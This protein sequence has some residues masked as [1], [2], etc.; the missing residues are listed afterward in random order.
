M[1]EYEVQWSR[2]CLTDSA[3]WPIVSQYCRSHWM[4]MCFLT[5]LVCCR[6]LLIPF[7]VCALPVAVCKAALAV[8]MCWFEGR[9][10]WYRSRNHGFAAGVFPIFVFFGQFVASWVV[11]VV[12]VVSAA[13]VALSWWLWLWT[14]IIEFRSWYHNT[15][16][17]YI[18]PS[19]HM[20]YR[21]KILN[22]AN[23]RKQGNKLR[24]VHNGIKADVVGNDFSQRWDDTTGLCCNSRILVRKAHAKGSRRSIPMSFSHRRRSWHEGHGNRLPWSCTRGL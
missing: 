1:R 7:D 6:V 3:C 12:V 15:S 13:V 24:T 17:M 16:P 10:S 19:P 22:T 20:V 9:I 14:L 18:S 8:G 2:C 5:P 4:K 11:I 23:S 21:Q